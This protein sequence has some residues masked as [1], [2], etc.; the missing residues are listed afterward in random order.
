MKFLLLTYEY[1]P[2]KGGIATYLSNLMDKTPSGVEVEVVV[3]KKGE[4]WI[5]TTLRLYFKLKKSKPDILAI[6]HVLPAG[7]TAFKMFFWLKVPY[8]V[9]THGTDI[10]SARRSS[11]K[12][13]WMRLVLRNAK[14]VIAN[15]RFTA[16][17]LREEGVAKIEIV[18]PSIV[19]PE[20][21]SGTKSG[22]DSRLRGNDIISIG[23]LVP[24]KGF[25]TLIKA[26]PLIL[27]EVP[28][29]HLKIIGRGDYYEELVRLTHE[30]RVEKFVD[31][32]NSVDDIASYLN[33][34]SVFALA[35]R[36]E[37]ADVEGF[38]I[39]TLEAS[40]A[41]LPVIV[42]NSGGAAEPVVDGVTGFVV[43]VEDIAS[44]IIKLLKDKSLAEKI[45]TT[46]REYV[47]KEYSAEAVASRFWKI[48]TK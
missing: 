32:L 30:L 35:A 45:G 37:G 40:A 43:K 9:F 38:G 11:W 7:Y 28:E 42:T 2:F 33:E 14:F 4:H 8:L 20:R 13:F 26:M 34:A 3:P 36:Q 19:V 5:L 29:A 47:T 15:S 18:T 27:K 10:L 39:V 22:L 24:R 44:T 1:P 21:T 48:V 6:S 41:G 31:I 23:R 17:L 25:D 16:G 46:G 12:K